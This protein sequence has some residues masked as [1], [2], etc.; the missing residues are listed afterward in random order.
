MLAKE[1]NGKEMRK[2]NIIEI[3]EYLLAFFLVIESNSVWNYVYLKESTTYIIMAI[4]YILIILTFKDILLSRGNFKRLVYVI[5]GISIYNIVFIMLNDINRIQFILQFVIIL[6]GLIIYQVGLINKENGSKLLLKMSN[7]IIILA[8]ISIIGYVFCTLLNVIHPSASIYYLW[9]GARYIPSYYGL[10]YVTQ[11]IGLH[12]MNFTRNS[13]VFTEGTMYAFVLT[14]SMMCELFLRKKVRKVNIIILIVAILST[15]STT[16]IV[17]SFGIIIC[18]LIIEVFRNKKWRK[19]GMIVIPIVVVVGVVVAGYFVSS[20]L[21]QG[22]DSKKASISI[23]TDD[24]RVGAEAFKDRPIIGYGY[25]QFN[26]VQ[27]YMN[28]KLR[29]NDI[30]GSSGVM[31]ILP[32]GGIYLFSMYLIPMLLA[33]GYGIKKRKPKYIII[34]LAMFVILVVTK[35][36]YRYLVMYFLALGWCFLFK[37][38]EEALE[39]GR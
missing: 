21:H 29:K 8:I 31:S 20:K 4:V 26:Y 12:G 34:S 1:M 36:E 23:R 18:R 3:I 17:V 7:I 38:G 2:A 27:Q 6:L 30:G 19:V 9:G 39:K 11:Y 14:V 16:G 28:L 13:G 37:R 24:M 32:E 35:I 5:L 10:Y 22:T 33:I 25:G 15:F